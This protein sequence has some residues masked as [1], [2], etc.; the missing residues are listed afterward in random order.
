MSFCDGIKFF[1]FYISV[2]EVLN[3]IAYLILLQGME[4]MYN[5]AQKCMQFKPGSSPHKLMELLNGI[6]GENTE[7]RGILLTLLKY[8]T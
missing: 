4:S 6:L 5:L 3:D 2:D 8:Y 7:V 1:I